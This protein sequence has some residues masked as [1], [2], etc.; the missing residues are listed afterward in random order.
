MLAPFDGGCMCGDVRY[1]CRSDPKMVYYCYCED[2]RRGSG[3]AFHVGIGVPRDSVSILQGEPK[4][5]RKVADSGN[6]IRR[7]FCSNCGSPLFIYP[8]MRPEIVMIKAGSL[9]EPSDLEPTTEIWTQSKVPWAAVK[10][11]IRSL[12]KGGL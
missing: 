9:D 5:W 4:S 11:G 10:P 6:G 8:D 3:S 1:R 7:V 12:E 2:C